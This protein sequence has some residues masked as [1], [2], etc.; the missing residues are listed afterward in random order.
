MH[1]NTLPDKD[2]SAKR[3]NSDGMTLVELVFAVGVLSVALG[4]M[5]SSL[6]SMYGMGQIAEGRTRAAM[7]MTSVM[8]DLR[9]LPDLPTVLAYTPG[10]IA[11]EDAEA[12]VLVEAI[13]ND[14]SPV[15]LPAAGNA[16][17][18]PNPVEVRTTVF[19]NQV[20]GR[21]FS[22]SGSTLISLR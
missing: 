18:F 5:F 11:F 6:V 15:P 14:G 10:D 22:M 8:D 19:W 3:S 16:A 17:T 20:R 12:V 21:T 1:V 7:I 13:A 2:W 4:I 9:E